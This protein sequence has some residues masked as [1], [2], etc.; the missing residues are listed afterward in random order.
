MFAKLIN[1]VISPEQIIDTLKEAYSTN[2][3][4]DVKSNFLIVKYL[5]VNDKKPKNV[6]NKLQLSI[7]KQYSIDLEETLKSIK[8]QPEDPTLYFEDDAELLND[9]E[10]PEPI[11]VPMS[12]LVERLNTYANITGEIRKTSPLFKMLKLEIEPEITECEIFAQDKYLFN[13]QKKGNV[14]DLKV[15]DEDLNEVD[16]N[17]KNVLQEIEVIEDEMKEKNCPRT[18]GGQAKDD[19]SYFED[20]SY[21]EVKLYSEDKMLAQDEKLSQNDCETIK[22][23]YDN[24]EED[25]EELIKK[26]TKLIEKEEGLLAFKDE[27]QKNIEEVNEKIKSNSLCKTGGGKRKTKK[28]N[29]KRSSKKRSGKRKMSS[30]KRKVTWRHR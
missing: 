19:K 15:V 8:K 30:K 28:R 24:L 26:E 22:K 1:K 12:L 2:H 5:G 16:G 17:I 9:T 29:K 10:D 18:K 4:N 23:K 14:I 3:E 13:R 7:G 11:P 21:P 25:K 6:I 20:K 27:I